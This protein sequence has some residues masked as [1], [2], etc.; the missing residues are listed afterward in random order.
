MTHPQALTVKDLRDLL[1]GHADHERVYVIMEDWM[2]HEYQRAVVGV[3]HSD[4]MMAVIV[5]V[6][7]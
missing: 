2:G 5:E 7:A 4:G 1:A 6:A 3:R